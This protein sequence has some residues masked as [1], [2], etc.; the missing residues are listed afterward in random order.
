MNNN[1]N[2]LVSMAGLWITLIAS[3][4][5]LLQQLASVGLL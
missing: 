1:A 5:I 3:I 2:E 4:A